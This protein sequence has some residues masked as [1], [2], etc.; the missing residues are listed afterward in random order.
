MHAL[1]EHEASARWRFDDA[2]QQIL[3]ERCG[4]PA[5]QIPEVPGLGGESV[6]VRP[7]P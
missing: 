7:E 5:T 4:P 6:R 3:A 2:K 1:F